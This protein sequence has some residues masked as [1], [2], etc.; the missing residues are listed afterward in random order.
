MPSGD[1]ADVLLV[2]LG[3]TGGLRRAD[4]EL[5]GSLRRAGARVAIARP[6]APRPLP[7]LMLTDLQWARA[8]RTAAAHAE[9]QAPARAIVYSTTTAALLWQRPGAIRFDATA[10]GNRPGHHGLWQRPLEQRRLGEAPLLLP[11]SDGGLREAPAAARRGDRALVLPV[12]VERSGPPG[13]ERDIAAI[14][15]AAN[16][17]K[18]GFDRVLAAWRRLRAADPSAEHELV[19]A[20]APV[21]HLRRAGLA[22]GGEPGVR[23]VGELGLDDFRGLLRRARVFVCAPRREDY[24]LV[25]LEALADGCQLVTTVAPG[26]YAA[27][28]IARDLD[29]Q[30]VG[31]DL[32]AALTAALSEPRADYAERARAALEPF[33]HEAVDKLVAEQLLPRLLA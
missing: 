17:H 22:P 13:G 11:W 27:L 20:G 23:V 21:E 16:P 15:Y 25:Q 2:S 9:R 24:G 28:P 1:R 29:A 26:P 14:T 31:D 7:T 6:D 8:A 19:V 32:T 18:K 33:T 5:A 3:S 10:A 30:L 4:D 12:P